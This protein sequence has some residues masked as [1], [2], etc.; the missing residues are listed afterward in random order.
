M[1]A[2]KSHGKAD[3]RI[4]LAVDIGGT[5]TDGVA[6][7]TRDGR[8]WVAKRLTTPD[9]PGLAVGTVVGELLEKIGRDLASHDPASLVVEVVHGTT[10]V[11]NAI[12][13][14]KGAKVGLLIT[15]GTRDTL[16]IR[17]EIRYDIYDLHLELPTPLAPRTLRLEVA[18]RLDGKGRTVVALDQDE[19]EKRIRQF[20]KKGVQAIAVCL[21]HA[22]AN[23]DHEKQIG[24]IVG[25]RLPGVGVSLSSRV[26]REIREFERMS[27]TVANAYVQPLM[28][29]YLTRLGKR[30]VDEG[31]KAPLRIMVSSGGFTSAEAAAEVPIQLLESGPAGGVLGGVNTALRNGHKDVLTFDMGGTTAKACV[32]TGG[33]P[34]VAHR[35]EAG[36]VHRFKKGSGVPILIPSIDLAEIGA[37]GGSI[38]HV[39][40]LGLLKV[41]PRS[42]GAVPGPA[43][44]GQGGREAT[45]TDA[46]LILGYLDPDYFLGGE[47]KLHPALAEKALG[48]LADSIDMKTLD[49]AWGIHDL[50]NE[51]MATT[52]RVHIAENGLDPRCLTMVATGG[53]GPVHAVAVAEKLGIRRVLCS[54]AAGAGSCLGLLAAPPRADRSWSEVSFL[55]DVDWRE[56]RR[57]LRHLHREA[58]AELGAAGAGGEGIV[59]TLG[60]EVRY[61]GQGNAIEVP[62]PYGDVDPGLGKAI[63]EGFE[64]G[65]AKLYGQA[66]PDGLPQVVTWRL[67]GVG[68]GASRRFR[69]TSESGSKTGGARPVGKRSMYLPAAAAHRRVPVFERYAIPA[70]TRLQG[71]LVLRE[72]ESTVVVARPGTVTILKDLTVAVSLD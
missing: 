72:R 25:D 69:L 41:G 28:E 58:E 8:I 33:M 9:D 3:R 5:F 29:S 49:V 6:N 17:R 66:V 65:Y 23:D 68:A 14:R 51:N 27:T 63:L 2:R 71:P 13:E 4:R 61:L 46:D 18:E 62:L 53:A 57:V 50:V 10:L 70:G 43:S 15:K 21:L 59:W 37:G 56:A 11:T 60:V 54:I 7:R 22:Y 1:S 30:L 35:F 19:V 32:A 42:S 16:D 45:V 48:R 20:K 55:E 40:H 38:A 26:A 34:A 36:R 52:A 47:M 64:R 44:Y 67:T 24:K 39:N 31:V 12:I